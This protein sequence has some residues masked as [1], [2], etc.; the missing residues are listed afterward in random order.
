[1]SSKINVVRSIKKV[2]HEDRYA[3]TEDGNQDNY[4]HVKEVNSNQLLNKIKDKL[5]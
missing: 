4:N 5:E 2:K 3:I 1:M